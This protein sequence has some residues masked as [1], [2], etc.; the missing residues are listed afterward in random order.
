MLTNWGDLLTNVPASGGTSIAPADY[1]N[2]LTVANQAARLALV[3][4]TGTGQVQELDQVLQTSDSTLWVLL[5]SDPSVSGNWSRLPGNDA[6]ALTTGTL[7]A[8]RYTSS[9]TTNYLQ[10]YNGTVL[11]NSSLSDNGSTV[12][13]LAVLGAYSSVDFLGN[14]GVT[15]ATSQVVR[16]ATGTLALNAST[17]LR[18]AINGTYLEN[19]SS[20]GLA[21]NKGTTAASKML[22]VVDSAAAQIRGTHTAGSAYFELQQTASAF[23]LS[24]TADRLGLGGVASASGAIAIGSGSVSDVANAA[25]LGSASYPISRLSGGKGLAHASPSS[26]RVQGTDGVGTDIS[27]GSMNVRGGCPTG[28]GNGGSVSLQTAPPGAS[29]TTIR[30]ALNR[31]EVDTHG[32]IW[33]HPVSTV[34]TSGV[35]DAIGLFSDAGVLKFIKPDNTV[36]TVPES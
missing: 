31:L 8:A 10:K 23:L 21:I 32:V 13:L 1:A 6:S 18:R 15:G 3:Y 7:P 14:G 4:G 25:V 26:W 34:P 27:G 29:G 24:T 12:S 30:G 28:S 11:V 19:L 36:I 22:E 20:T 16:T 2:T 33:I 9:P 35:D 5:A 17:S